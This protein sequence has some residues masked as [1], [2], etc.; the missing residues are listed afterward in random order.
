MIRVLGRH[1]HVEQRLLALTVLVQLLR[2]IIQHLVNRLAS[3]IRV[4]THIK[5]RRAQVQQSVSRVDKLLRVTDNLTFAVTSV[6][7]RRCD[8]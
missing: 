4:L 3:V 8:A 1:K 2:N 7:I 5:R 6:H